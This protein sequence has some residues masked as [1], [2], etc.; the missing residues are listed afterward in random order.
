MD[1]EIN[2]NTKLVRVTPS[3]VVTL[4][5]VIETI[6]PMLEHLD[7]EPGMPSL[8]DYRACPEVSFS[9]EELR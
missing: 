5:L 6:N 9:T 1:I 4:E 2:T 7:F 3:G 8:W